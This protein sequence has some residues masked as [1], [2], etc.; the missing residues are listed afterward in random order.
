MKEINW[1]LRKPEGSGLFHDSRR[2]A[3]ITREAINLLVDKI[4][5]LVKKVN[6]LES[7]S[8]SK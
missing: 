5:E 1:A 4:N 6:E 7:R 2:D 3:Q 8:N